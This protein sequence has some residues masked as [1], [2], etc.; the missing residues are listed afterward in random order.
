MRVSLLHTLHVPSQVDEQPTEYTPYFM[1][2]SRHVTFAW[3]SFL[4]SALVS[5]LV[6]V[7]VS[8]ICVG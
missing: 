8:M 7:R 2:Q 4:M 1:P 5:F 3:Y 6:S